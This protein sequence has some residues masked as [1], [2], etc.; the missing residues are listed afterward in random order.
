MG[1]HAFVLACYSAKFRGTLV[2]DGGPTAALEWELL[3][4][5]LGQFKESIFLL[6]LLGTVCWNSFIQ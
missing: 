3:V 5:R 6:G 1:V 2:F 4:E